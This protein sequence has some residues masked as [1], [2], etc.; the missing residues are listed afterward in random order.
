MHVGQKRSDTAPG[1]DVSSNCALTVCSL[2]DVMCDTGLP[3]PVGS[4]PTV[5]STI[6]L[7]SD[8]TSRIGVL[9]TT[10]ML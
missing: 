9:T 8:D 1:I 7:L 4:C 2:Q 10:I 3:S 5:V 6:P